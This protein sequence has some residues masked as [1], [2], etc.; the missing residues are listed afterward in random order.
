MN[1]LVLLLALTST[2]VLR[3]GDRVVTEGAVREENGR[4]IFRAGG[5]LYSLAAHE[6][7]RVEKNEAATK[8]EKPVKR[9]RVSEEERKR[10]L[11]ELE[12]N[13]GGTPAPR[14]PSLERA[15][16]PPTKAEVAEQKREER[17]WRTEA[18]ALE[19]SVRRAHEDVALL[20][21]RIAELQSKIQGLIAIGYKPH[22]FTYDTTQL[23]RTQERLPYA[24]LAL[25][26]AQ[27]EYE[28]FREDA[29]REGVPPGWLR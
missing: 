29:R 9:L 15:P 21:S 23:V 5:Q 1:A 12:K 11:A 28:Q 16:E 7:E 4:V 18:R 17:Q 24:R 25:Q 3:S 26:R 10:L 6:V 8:D 13:H 2:I 27:R 22:Q 20:E 14:Q 19:E